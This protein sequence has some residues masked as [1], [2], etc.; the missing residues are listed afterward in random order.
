[1]WFQK[2]PYYCD[3]GRWVINVDGSGVE[4]PDYAEGFPRYFFSLAR[5]VDEM[6]E[7][8]NA[9][10]EVRKDEWQKRVKEKKSAIADAHSD[11]S[12]SPPRNQPS[13]QPA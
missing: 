13:G 11:A 5:A 4:G 7:W 6:E 3:R 2:R 12:A 1:M 10:S 8:I 9:R